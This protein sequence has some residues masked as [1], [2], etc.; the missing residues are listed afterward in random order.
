MRGK[1]ARLI[2]VALA[3]ITMSLVVVATSPAAAIAKNP[4]TMILR[5]ADIGRGATYEA[6]DYVDQHYDDALDAAGV[7]FEEANYFGLTYSEAKGSLRVSGW[8]IVTPS[9]ARARKAF[10]A[11]LKGQAAWLRT[12]RSPKLAPLTLPSYGNQQAAGLDAID[13]GTGIGYATILVRK[14]TVVW[15]LHVGH[16]RRPPRSRADLIADLRR[17]AAKQAQR[18]GGGS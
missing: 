11:G 12:I 3:A 10:T 1:I 2:G 15:F 16:E 7:D 8:V 18:V 17:L 6:D 4:A 5:Q 9:P 14:N 13:P